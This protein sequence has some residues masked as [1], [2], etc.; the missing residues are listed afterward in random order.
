MMNLPLLDRYLYTDIWS[1]IK[2]YRVF[3][4]MKFDYD[5]KIAEMQRS[6]EDLQRMIIGAKRREYDHHSKRTHNS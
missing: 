5:N 6:I 2:Y 1:T 4:K 3:L